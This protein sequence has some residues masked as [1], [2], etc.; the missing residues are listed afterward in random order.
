MSRSFFILFVFQF[1]DQLFEIEIKFIKISYFI[2][3][4]CFV[5]ILTENAEGKIKK[6]IFINI[7]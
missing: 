5:I 4:N 7:K 6:N 3:Y 1:I 2:Y